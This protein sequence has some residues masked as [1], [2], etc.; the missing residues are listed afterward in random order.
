MGLYSGGLIHGS[1][2]YGT[3]KPFFYNIFFDLEILN[4]KIFL[5]TLDKIL[6]LFKLLIC[7]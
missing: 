1:L 7:L 5:H 2:R 4:R 3:V 6:F